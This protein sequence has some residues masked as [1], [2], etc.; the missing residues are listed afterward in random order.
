MKDPVKELITKIYLKWFEE[1][2][3]EK[4]DEVILYGKTLRINNKT[5]EMDIL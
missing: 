4:L 3:S 1:N 5:G 2:V